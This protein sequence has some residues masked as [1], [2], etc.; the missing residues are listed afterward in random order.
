MEECSY[1]FDERNLFQV[2]EEVKGSSYW[3]E[4]EGKQLLREEFK[5]K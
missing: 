3:K 2:S 1:G 5:Y 4:L